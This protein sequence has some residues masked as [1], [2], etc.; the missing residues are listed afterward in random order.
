MVATRFKS[1][2]SRDSSSIPYSS[3]TR[4]F[5]SL[6]P[7][8]TK[9]A[10][11]AKGKSYKG[12][13]LRCL[14]KKVRRSDAATDKNLYIPLKILARSAHVSKPSDP[15]S[16]VTVKKEVPDVSPPRTTQPSTSSSILGLRVSIETMVLDFDSSDDRGKSHVTPLSPPSPHESLQTNDEETSDDT[17]EDYVPIF[18]KTPASEETTVFVM[19]LLHFLTIECL[20]LS[21]LRCLTSRPPVKGQQVVSTKAGCRKI[22]PNVPFMPI[23]GVSF[24]FKK[25]AYKWKYVVRR[26]IVDESNIFNQYQSYLVILDLICNARLIRTVS[27]VGPFYPRLIRKL[28]VNLPSDFNDPSAEEFH[29]VHIRELPQYASVS[30]L[31]YSDVSAEFDNA[32]GRFRATAATNPTV[33]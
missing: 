27:K 18:E 30:R 28:A 6:A 7:S 17:D 16:S 20:S 22:P 31:P 3:G 14:F 26:C 23:D 21:Q 1:Y 11:P 15:V 9:N 25:G 8:P 4:V 12:I 13:P 32:L 2:Q 24:H 5:D 29:K 33:G 10:P 19:I